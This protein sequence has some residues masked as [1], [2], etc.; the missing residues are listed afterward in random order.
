MFRGHRNAIVCTRCNCR[1]SQWNANL[2][3]FA[4]FFTSRWRF[5]CV[6]HEPKWL[7]LAGHKLRNWSSMV[8]SNFLSWRQRQGQ[9]QCNAVL[10]HGLDPEAITISLNGSRNDDDG[11]ANDNKCSMHMNYDGMDSLLFV[12]SSLLFYKQLLSVLF[13]ACSWLSL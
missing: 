6:M 12:L 2:Y 7:I 3:R 11:N 5:D 10:W 1:R 8:S 9:G 13:Y 4:D